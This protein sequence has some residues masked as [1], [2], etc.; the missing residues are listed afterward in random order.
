MGRFCSIMGRPSLPA[1]CCSLAKTFCPKNLSLPPPLESVPPHHQMPLPLLWKDICKINLHTEHWFGKIQKGVRLKK[2]GLRAERQKEALSEHFMER[3]S[4]VYFGPF[5]NLNTWHKPLLS[6]LSP[7][8]TQINND[9]FQCQFLLLGDCRDLLCNRLLWE[10]PPTKM[11]K[12][13][14]IF[15]SEFPPSSLSPS[16]AEKTY[17]QMDSGRNNL[18]RSTILRH[19][20]KFETN[21]SLN[22]DRRETKPPYIYLR[23]QELLTLPCTISGQLAL[24]TLCS[25][26]QLTATISQ[27]SLDNY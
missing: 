16:P 2:V 6:E 4:L 7:N 20:S 15:I 12:R 22:P 19:Q 8:I 11:E 14:F 21:L 13:R 3:A 25:F 26:S 5:L 1:C 18:C 24:T 9:S 23:W 10:F 27:Q 17:M